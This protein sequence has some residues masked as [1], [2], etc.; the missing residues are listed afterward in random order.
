MRKIPAQIRAMNGTIF[1]DSTTSPGADLHSHQSTHQRTL[2]GVGG[3]D[4]DI[5]ITTRSGDYCGYREHAVQGVIGHH[6]RHLSMDLFILDLCQNRQ[7]GVLRAHKT[8]GGVVDLPHSGIHD[9]I[10]HPD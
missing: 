5:V 9:N 6:Q 8:M 1:I 7:A 10:G 4:G 2:A 3:M